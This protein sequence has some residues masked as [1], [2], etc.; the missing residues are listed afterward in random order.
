M[1]ISSSTIAWRSFFA[2]FHE[3]FQGK[4]LYILDEPE[5]ALSPFRQ[6]SLLVRLNELVHQESQFIISTHSPLLMA[7][8]QAKLLE[9]TD[10]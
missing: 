6:M 1:Q 2:A 4:G 8:P 7:Y 5:V 10:F 3:W 9:I